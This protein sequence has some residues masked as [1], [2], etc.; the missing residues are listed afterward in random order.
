MYSSVVGKQDK[1]LNDGSQNPKSTPQTICKT[2]HV[3]ELV[4]WS[5]PPKKEPRFSLLPGYTL[6]VGKNSEQ[7]K[8]MPFSFPSL[9]FSLTS[10]WILLEPK[11]V[12]LIFTWSAERLLSHR[13][14][15][16]IKMPIYLCSS[17]S[18]LVLARRA[19][20]FNYNTM[21]IGEHLFPFPQVSAGDVWGLEELKNG[22]NLRQW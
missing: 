5:P 4:T 1:N 10:S 17:W 9:L 2:H 22:H 20:S 21:C 12:H 18:K 7:A 19:I 3:V 6:D 14:Y 13:I 8:E 16:P 15:L 11:L